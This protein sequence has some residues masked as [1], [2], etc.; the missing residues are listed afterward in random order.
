MHRLADRARELK[1]SVPAGRV[2]A[3]IGNATLVAVLI[4]V[5]PPGLDVNP[6]EMFA[7]DGRLLVELEVL[8]ERQN[9]T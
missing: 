4:V 2:P 1:S 7:Q 8:A 6:V 5:R 3:A 9:G